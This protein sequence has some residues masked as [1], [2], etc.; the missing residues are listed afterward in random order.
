MDQ[1]KGSPIEQLFFYKRG[2]VYS[3]ELQFLTI[4]VALLTI[5]SLTKL[6]PTTYGFV[7]LLLAFTFL[8]TNSFVRYHDNSISDFNIQTYRKHA[9]LQKVCNDYLQ[10]RQFDIGK[11]VDLNY[12]H[13]DAELI[14]F[15]HSLLPLYEYNPNEFYLLLKGINNILEIKQQIE[16]YYTANN[17]TPSTTSQ[18]LEDAIQLRAQTINN[19]H[20]FIYAVPKVHQMYR[21]IDAINDRYNILITRNTDIIYK[22][23][24][25]HNKLNGINSSTIYISYNETKPY[26][27]L[28]NHQI[29]VTK[30]HTE[31]KVVPWY[32]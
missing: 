31:K 9:V 16:E 12:M 14:Q 18:M 11:S 1:L 6:F 29:D 27:A 3:R 26:D 24:L 30:H 4:L 2:S 7:I 23:Y 8:V 5:F 21:Y 15:M 13:N 10:S 25:L 20:N 17:T 28:L 22:Y 32:I 19:V